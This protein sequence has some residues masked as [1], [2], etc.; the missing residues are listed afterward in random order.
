[1]ASVIRLVVNAT[2]NTAASL[3]G[4]AASVRRFSDDFQR[5]GPMR[6]LRSINDFRQ[7]SESR[8]N[9][10]FAGI[11]DTATRSI[12]DGMRG[13]IG[14]GLR[15]AFSN[16]A[17]GAAVVT[18]ATSL[19]A[20]LSAAIAGALVLALGGAIVGLGIFMAAK[21]KEVKKAWAGTMEELK[22]LFQ[23]AAEPMLP[24]IETARK[25]F[26]SLAKDFA[27]H[28]KE[29]MEAAAPHMQVFTE[30]LRKGF[31][32][33]G[34]EAWDD[35]TESFNVF[36]AA[37]GPQWEDFMKELGSSLG[38]LSRT[39]SRHSEEIA[40][41]LRFV[42]GVINLLIDAVNFFSNV[43]VSGMH[44]VADSIGF[45]VKSM[46]VLIDVFLGAI[47]VML[48]GIAD[49][50]GV[51]GMDGPVR[52]A[53]EN[54]DAMRNDIKGKFDD[55]ANRATEWGRTLDEKSRKRKLEVDITSW[56][57]QLEA[58]KR[59]LNSVPKEKRSEVKANIADLERKIR[60]AKAE[61][62]MIKNKTVYVTM[63]L[64]DSSLNRSK[65]TVGGTFTRATGGNIGAAATGGIRSN[66]T[67]VGERGPELVDLPPGSHVRSNGDSMRM[68]GAAGNGSPLV[69]N[70]S[71]DGKKMA[72]VMIDP[73]R[74]EILNLSG[75][76]VQAALG[77]GR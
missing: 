64:V 17:V 72:S 19:A 23:K 4:A 74:G 3:R 49:V 31:E 66:M 8:F 13:G 21:S 50:A 77:R 55:M 76:N 42:L 29:A 53:K 38:A 47:S 34:K 1:M 28:F 52:R 71:L 11:R 22:P 30:S 69:V 65:I 35:L 48:E 5:N 16:P 68:M 9:S 10:F 70:L 39:V 12:S 24:V 61:L 56:T 2:N 33:L 14:N 63:N 59:N 26:E 46:G 62:A 6:W 41:A 37:F 67:L 18:L 32:N 58:A 15:T 44:S 45:V 43:W 51:I 36:L 40:L 25:K 27:P 75:G 54:F 57:A 20:V 60:I 7:R 73:L